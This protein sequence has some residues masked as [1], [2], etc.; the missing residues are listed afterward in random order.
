M[1]NGVQTLSVAEV[2]RIHEVLVRDFAET[3]DPIGPMGL[4]DI[5]LLESAVNRQ[6]SGFLSAQ[7]YRE[8]LGSAATLTYGICCDHAFVNGNKRTALVAML[9]HL[10]KNNLCLHSVKESELYQLMLAIA[11]HSVGVRPV[12]RRLDRASTRRR[13]DEEVEAIREWLL[14]RATKVNRGER[15]ITYRQL[16]RILS[17]FDIQLGTPHS[18]SVDVT[19]LET[20]ET[21]FLRRRKTQ[22]RRLGTIGYHDEGAEVSL[23]DLKAVRRMCQLTEQDG[24]DS[25]AFY[26]DADVIDA[27]VNRYRTVLRRLART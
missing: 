7:K 5:G 22:V 4:R 19:R 18:N 16:R 3:G 9:V 25:D 26:G 2:L 24:V 21:A 12:S 6:H 15:L 17:R 1:S 11:D 23:K 8:P 10:D 13:S 27:F 14:G 20:I